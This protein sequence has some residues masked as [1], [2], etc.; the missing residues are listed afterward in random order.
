MID[1]YIAD[2]TALLGRGTFG[3]VYSGTDTRLNFQV[4][5]K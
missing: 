5:I 1:N 2:T 4:A 3:K